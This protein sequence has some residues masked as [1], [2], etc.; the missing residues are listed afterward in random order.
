MIGILSFSPTDFHS[1]KIGLIRVK[2]YLPF[3]I[4]FKRCFISIRQSY[5]VIQLNL[6]SQTLWVSQSDFLNLLVRLTEYARIVC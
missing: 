6:V 5:L 4:R 3:Q 1:E 2:T